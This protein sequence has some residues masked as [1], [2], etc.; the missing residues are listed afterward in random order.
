MLEAVRSWLIKVLSK[1]LP[2]LFRLI[3][4]NEKMLGMVDVTISSENE[5]L[6]V[7]CADLPDARVWLE[8]TNLS[9]FTLKLTGIEAV[10]LWVGRAAEFRS[11]HC[12]NIKP[13]SK[14]KIL[15]ETSINELQARHIREKN[16][17]DKPR[18]SVHAFFESSIR[19]LSKQRE[20]QTSNF[21]LLNCGV[22]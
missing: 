3:Y 4:S 12:L 15:I 7:N 18:L 16:Q 6:V 10:L 13:H 8:I 22:A 9:P 2:S 19:P 21:R 5:G 17:L 1:L 11:L 20:I 14:E